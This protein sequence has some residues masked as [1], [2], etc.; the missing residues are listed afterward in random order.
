[1][2]G[3]DAFQQVT[4]CVRGSDLLDSTPRQLSLA[5]GTAAVFVPPDQG[6]TTIQTPNATVGLNSSGVVVRYVPSRGLT[7]V[8]ALAN[9][10]TGPISVTTAESGQEFALYA[11]Q[12]AFVNVANL[13]IVEFDLLEFY[14]TSDLVA[15]LHLSEFDYQPSD[16]EPL[17][18][19]RPDLLQAIAQQP[20]FDSQ[21]FILDP[22]LIS[23]FGSGASLQSGEVEQV[24]LPSP[25]E[26]LRRYNE[27]PPGVVNPLPVNPAEAADPAEPIAPPEPGTPVNEALGDG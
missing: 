3:D 9:S 22:A 12:M 19:L 26:E 23:D 10:A 25:T 1:M 5:Q 2:V 15:G 16:N 18:A 21:D 20:P 4:H 8:M 13:Q 14:H 7:L 6:R 24:V 17:A 11:G 27:A